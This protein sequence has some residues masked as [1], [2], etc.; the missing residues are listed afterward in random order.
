MKAFMGNW[1]SSLLQPFCL[2]SQDTEGG[3]QGKG[4]GEAIAEAASVC[5]L[6][7]L[8]PQKT[9]CC[10]TQQVTRCVCLAPRASGCVHTSSS[11]VAVVKPC[12]IVVHV[13]LLS[14]PHMCMC[15][16]THRQYIIGY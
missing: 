6:I 7:T 5:Y 9:D 16:Q 11:L 1:L 8:L 4:A 3:Q 14:S 12:V 13:H 10:C 2:C 15:A